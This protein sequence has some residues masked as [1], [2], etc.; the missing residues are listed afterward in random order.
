MNTWWH[1]VV[2]DVFNGKRLGKILLYH[3]P[4]CGER[5]PD[6][7]IITVHV[8]FVHIVC[9]TQ[10]L[11]KLLKKVSTLVA[12]KNSRL[13][14][15][16]GYILALKYEIKWKCLFSSFTLRSWFCSLMMH[17]L[18]DCIVDWSI[19]R[20]IWLNDFILGFTFFRYFTLGWILIF[21]FNG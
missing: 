18:K 2:R 14:W 17:Q 9:N 15:S 12:S 5:F 1:V 3:C 8:R 20:L 4:S 13:V 21:K 19:R 6:N 7:H 11:S 16:W 10:S